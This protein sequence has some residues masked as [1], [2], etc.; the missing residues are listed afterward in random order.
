MMNAALLF[1]D[2][3]PFAVAQTQQAMEQSSLVCQCIAQIDALASLRK[4]SHFEPGCYTAC[5][6]QDDGRLANFDHERARD[7]GLASHDS[8]V[9]IPYLY[10]VACCLNYMGFVA[11][12][13]T[14]LLYNTFCELFSSQLCNLTHKSVWN[15]CW[16]R[17]NKITCVMCTTWT[18]HGSIVT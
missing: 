14:A 5:V 13:D 8:W 2:V 9:C 12:L 11:H 1:G 16:R 15:C 3:Q 17:P 6:L 18:F 7:A 4:P 10:L